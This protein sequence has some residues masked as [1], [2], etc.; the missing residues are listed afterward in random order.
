M[1][2]EECKMQ[3]P[4]KVQ[5]RG[6]IY[7]KSSFSMRSMKC[8]AVRHEREYVIV[9]STVQPMPEVKFT[10]EE[11]DAFIKGVKAGQFG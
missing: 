8:V 10:F 4:T 9:T 11:W 5:I 2:V 6:K 1:I 7:E 3:V